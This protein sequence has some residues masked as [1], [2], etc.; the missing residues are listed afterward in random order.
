MPMSFGR[1][2]GDGSA[3]PVAFSTSIPLNGQYLMAQQ[4]IGGPLTFTVAAG[5]IAFGSCYLRL[6]A[7]GANAPI[8]PGYPS[9]SSNSW[10]NT[11]GRINLVTV[12]HDGTQTYHSIS[13]GV[14]EPLYVAPPGTVTI[15]ATPTSTSVSVALSVSGGGTPSDY[16]VQYRVQGSGAWLD[17]VD[18][19]SAVASVSVSGLTPSTAYEF[20]GRASNASGDSAWSATIVATTSAVSVIQHFPLEVQTA[21]TQGGDSSVGYS[22]TSTAGLFGSR[23]GSAAHYLDGDGYIQARISSGLGLVGFKSDPAKLGTAYSDSGT[24]ILYNEAASVLK[25]V[26]GGTGGVTC[27]VNATY[28]SALPLFLRVRRAGTTLYAEASPDGSSWTVVHQASGH[29]GRLYPWIGGYQTGDAVANV[30]SEG[31]A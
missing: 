9:N 5:A 28:S 1:V 6:V 30:T 13:Q 31:L 3:L 15:T 10:D 14:G 11:A 2:Q 8:F 22:Y 26:T 19:V 7:N 29:T 27:N 21:M 18:G 20:R 24:F 16:S 25:M 23:A 17:F 12:W 4:A